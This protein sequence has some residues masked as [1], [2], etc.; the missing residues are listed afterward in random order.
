MSLNLPTPAPSYS[1]DNEAQNRRALQTEDLRNV[2]TSDYATATKRGI[3]RVDNSTIT[4]AADGTITAVGGAGSV[5]TVTSVALACPAQFTVWLADHHGGDDYSSLGESER[6]SGAGGPGDGCCGGAH[7]PRAGG[8]GY[9]RARGESLGDCGR[10]GGE[11]QRHH[12]HA[13]RCRAPGAEG[14][15]FSL[16][17]RQGGRDDDHREWRRDFG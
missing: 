4:A 14:E 8:G 10:C 7:I 1:Q 11:R 9:S 3:V 12:L 17:H 6:Q 13:E 15:R 5:G 16:R 2:K